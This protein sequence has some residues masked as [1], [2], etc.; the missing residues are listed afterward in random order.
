MNTDR[1]IT[2]LDEL[3][4]NGD[5]EFKSIPVVMKTDGGTK[6]VYQIVRPRLINVV[7]I[8]V[9]DGEY[10]RDATNDDRDKIIEQV[11]CLEF[12]TTI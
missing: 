9:C 3:A 6:S 5:G 12:D 1:M 7:D 11:V 2:R 4:R 10:F 8:G